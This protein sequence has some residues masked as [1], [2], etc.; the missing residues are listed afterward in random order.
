ME[1]ADLKWGG[2]GGGGGQGSV[3]FYQVIT[4]NA[5]VLEMEQGVFIVTVYNT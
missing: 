2:G 1:E 3:S 5:V 4:E